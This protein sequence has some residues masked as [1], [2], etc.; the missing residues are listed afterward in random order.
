M[1]DGIINAIKNGLKGK[2]K[3]KS[4]NYSQIEFKI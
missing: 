4:A 2:K 1:L 3:R